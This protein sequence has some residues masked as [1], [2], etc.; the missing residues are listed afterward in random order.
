MKT[1]SYPFV[2]AL[3]TDP[4]GKV[5]Q[6]VLDLVDYE[7]LLEG[8]EDKRLIQAMKDAEGE[9]SLNLQEALAEMTRA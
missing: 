6:V 9:S 4:H 8:I 2:K 5:N 3:I 1:E 7:H